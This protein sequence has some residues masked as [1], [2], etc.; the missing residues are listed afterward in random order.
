MT[1]G[2]LGTDTLVDILDG[3]ASPAL[4]DRIEHHASRC[5]ACRQVLSS[6]ARSDTPPVASTRPRHDAAR[7]LARGTVVGRYEIA[8]RIGEGGMGVVYAARDPELD[9]MVAIKLLHGDG[10]PRMQDRLRREA[11]AMA[12][13]A[14]PNVVAVHDV[15]AFG[16]H[17]FIA[18]EYVAGETLARWSSTTR[19]PHEI[20]E[21]YRAAGR[22]L[23]AAH[24]VGIVHRDFKPE[25]VVIGGDGRPRVGDFGLA[26]AAGTQG[27]IHG[28]DGVRAAA[29]GERTAPG[30]LLGTPYYMAPELYRGAEAD[31]RSDQFSF[32]VALFTALH[33]VR[34]F[35]GDRV[36]ELAAN[37][38]A[39]RLRS[40][41]TAG[42]PRRIRAAIERG[43]AVDPAR[44][45]ATLDGLLDAL[46]PPT[47]RW[48]RAALALGAA[49]AVGG[50]LA[51]WLAPAAPDERCTGGAAAF[52][53]AWNPG[54]RA[55][56]M[57]AFHATGAPYATVA[58]D[59]VVRAFDAYA[60][61]WAQA[62]TATCRA[63]R[64]LGEQTEGMLELRMTCL[65]R[66]REEAGALAGALAAADAAAV[67]HAVTAT[68]DLGDVAACADVAALRQVAAPPR[69]PAARIQLAGLTS[70]LAE[71]R[72]SYETGAYPHAL[73]LVRPAAA[74]ARTFGYRPLEAEAELLQGQIER[75]T[76]DAPHA[77][78]ALQ[79][80][81]WAAEA[82][83]HD[84]VAA[85]AWST[86]VFL[87]GYDEAQ[88]ARGLGLVPRATAAIARL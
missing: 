9:R 35:A 65:E 22:G 24:A 76:G 84:E 38:C 20:L 42:V 32:C 56:I 25:N 66:R 34:P 16:R 60:T 49:L 14:H 31:A 37:V 15:G 81:V 55:A 75:D 48:T 45:F 3:H 39:G 70:Q 33:G 46:A 4:R 62:H 28:P 21:V 83:R 27:E 88:Y 63:T 1:D 6:L 30:L 73:E 54:R 78:A 51:A 44:R 86:L 50:A 19:H 17:V 13:L 7:E 64:V 68:L 85:R 58:L 80:A 82:G 10:D 71:A 59:Q 67:T 40:A 23:A 77:E 57:A 41:P 52:G 87:V 18:M 36:D 43:L 61:R 74:A 79:A 29:S 5:A 53:S 8:Y 12:Q 72:A 47:V 11:Q 69:G 26:R 2:C